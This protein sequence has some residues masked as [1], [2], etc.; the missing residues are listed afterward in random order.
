MELSKCLLNHFF[1]NLVAHFLSLNN[2]IKFT[3]SYQSEFNE[4]GIELYKNGLYIDNVEP[5]HKANVL[6]WIYL[7]EQELTCHEKYDL[8]Y[9]VDNLENNVKSNMDIDV[10]HAWA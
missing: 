5:K 6:E 1:R 7:V 10:A 8:E 2:N 9:I 3:Y 4:L